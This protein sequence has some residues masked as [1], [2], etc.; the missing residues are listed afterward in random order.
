MDGPVINMNGSNNIVENNY[1]HSID[2]SCTFRG[3]YTINML[4]ST[5]LLFRRNTVHTAGA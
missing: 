5:D 1:M 2:Y 3:G 4:R